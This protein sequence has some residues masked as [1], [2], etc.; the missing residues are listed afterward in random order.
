MRTV[1]QLLKGSKIHDPLTSILW[2]L[3]AMP[4]KKKPT[5]LTRKRTVTTRVAEAGGGNKQRGRSRYFTRLLK[6]KVKEVAVGTDSYVSAKDAETQTEF[7][8]GLDCNVSAKDAETQ[9]EYP[10]MLRA[11]ALARNLAPLG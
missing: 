10:L 4:P 3:R 7:A 2:H 8:E 11:L 6:Y 9:F 1:T 5:K